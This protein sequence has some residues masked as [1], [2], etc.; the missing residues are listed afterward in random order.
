MT[1]KQTICNKWII[2]AHFCCLSIFCLMAMHG[3]SQ[4]QSVN[5]IQNISFGVFTQGNS[6]GEIIIASNGSRSATGSVIPLHF[7]QTFAQAIFE[8]E[9]IP[10]TVVSIF[11][12]QPFTALTGS[13]GGSMSLAIG[14]TD[15]VSPFITTAVPPLKTTVNIGGTLTVGMQSESPPG[16]YSG[17]F[18]ITF[19]NE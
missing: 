5:T 8:I 17:T 18:Y 4:I 11:L 13:N 10:G 2:G 16:I 6:G 19:N 12:N 9:A 3:F 15:P 1:Q 14:I 7:G